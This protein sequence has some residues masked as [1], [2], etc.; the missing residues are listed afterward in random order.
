MS[1]YPCTSPGGSLS[2]RSPSVLIERE[3][4]GRTINTAGVGISA[5]YVN[6][7]PMLRRRRPVNCIF[8]LNLFSSRLPQDQEGTGLKVRSILDTTE[9]T[10]PFQ[11]L[12]CAPAGALM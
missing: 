10:A 6:M 2:H 8:V 7:H 9:R 4:A 12:S 1:V 11:W 3:M 5:T